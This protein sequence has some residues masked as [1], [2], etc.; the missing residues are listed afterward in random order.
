M[1]VA[2]WLT[3]LNKSI[4]PNL[5]EKFNKDSNGNISLS[6]I[7]LLFQASNHPDVINGKRTQGE[8]YGEFLDNIETYKE[9]LENMRGI[10]TNNFSLEDFVN[11]YYL[12]GIG[13]ADD[14]LFEFMIKNC[15]NGGSN[16]KAYGNGN[17]N[18]NGRN[19]GTLMA[20]AGSQIINNN[21]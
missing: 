20:R 16:Y 9:Y 13:I 17:N 2:C 4:L 6:E 12:I 3:F 18:F 15:W 10:Y 11:F 8:I 7:K 5:Y 1:A 21:Y 19:Q 14:K